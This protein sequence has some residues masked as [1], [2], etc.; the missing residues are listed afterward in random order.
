M[1]F[2]L[3]LRLGLDDNKYVAMLET[4]QCCLLLED[5]QA[6]VA[7]AEAELPRGG[8]EGHVLGHRAD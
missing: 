8:D 3:G 4:H 2:G 1:D 5:L 7:G 6:V